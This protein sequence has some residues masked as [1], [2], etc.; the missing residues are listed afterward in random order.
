[1]SAVTG[2][3]WN[4]LIG[5]G[6]LILTIGLVAVLLQGFEVY[7]YPKKWN[8]ELKNRYVPKALQTKNKKEETT[9]EERTDDD[10]Q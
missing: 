6:G 10:Q 1:M 8:E 9:N 4:V 7:K 5:V 3:E 2:A